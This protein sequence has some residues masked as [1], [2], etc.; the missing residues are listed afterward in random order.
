MTTTQPA[1]ERHDAVPELHV[2]QYVDDHGSAAKVVE[3]KR[4]EV[5]IRY[6]DSDDKIWLMDHQFQERDGRVVV[7]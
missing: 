3:I 1:H 7:V 2:G 5:L 6:E 4:G